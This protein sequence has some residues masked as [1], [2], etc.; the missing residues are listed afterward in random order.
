MKKEYGVAFQELRLLS[1][2]Y[3]VRIAGKNL[4]SKMSD[5]QKK[6]LEKLGLKLEVE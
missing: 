4:I 2:V 3:M 6:L 1:T 5:E